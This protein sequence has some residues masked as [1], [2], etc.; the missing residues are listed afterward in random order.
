VL[1][2]RDLTL[3]HLLSNLM[4]LLKLSLTLAQ[5]ADLVL[6]MSKLSLQL[7]RRRGDSI[8][9]SNDI[10]GEWISEFGELLA[11]LIVLDLALQFSGEGLITTLNASNKLLVAGLHLLHVDVS[12]NILSDTELSKFARNSLDLCHA[13]L[14]RIL[15][16]CT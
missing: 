6:N 14:G 3:F 15:I 7:F 5:F 12:V 11:E 10:L 13:L 16:L 9:A 2:V 1:V 8:L 4:H